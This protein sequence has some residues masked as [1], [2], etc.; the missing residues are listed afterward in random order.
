MEIADDE[1]YI[2]WNLKREY[3]IIFLS[4]FTASFGGWQYMSVS[5]YCQVLQTG[6]SQRIKWMTED[7]ADLVKDAAY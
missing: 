5:Y 4:W 1:G 2:L 3:Y 6:G 7:Q